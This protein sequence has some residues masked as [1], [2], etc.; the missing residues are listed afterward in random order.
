[1]PERTEGYIYLYLYIQRERERERER[2]NEEKWK[3]KSSPVLKRRL[4]DEDD[5]LKKMKNKITNLGGAR[6]RTTKARRR[7][8]K[9]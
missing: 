2:V 8:R 1:M 7:R 6:T 9:R 3:R 4:D 5:G